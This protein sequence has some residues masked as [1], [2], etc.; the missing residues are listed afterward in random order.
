MASPKA[1]VLDA[2]GKTASELGLDEAV[3]AAE[4]KPH[5]VHETVRAELNAERASQQTPGGSQEAKAP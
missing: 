5:L 4:I 1:A 2:A 3:F